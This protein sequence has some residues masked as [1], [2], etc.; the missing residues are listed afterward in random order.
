MSANPISLSEIPGIWRGE[1]IRTKS[2]TEP[3]GSHELDDAVLG[4]WPIGALTQIIGTH[5]GLGFSLAI[6][7]LARL[8]Q[9]GR[10][11]GLVQSPFL[12]YAPSLSSQ[13]VDLKHLLWV[14]PADP[15]QALWAMEQMIRSGLFSAVAYWGKPLDGTSERRLQL[16]ADA[17]HC[18]AFCFRHGRSDDHTYAALR[19]KVAPATRSRLKVD[20][21]KC[22]GGRAGFSVIQPPAPSFSRRPA[23]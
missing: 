13:G 21:L 20:V 14:Q 11:V 8:T 16:A 7:T 17:G 15:I 23:A 12:P 22:R 1:R 3:T 4:G 9:A 5:E 6:P 2:P 19:L 10:Y 18:L